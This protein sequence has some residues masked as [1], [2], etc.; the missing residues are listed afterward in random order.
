MSKTVLDQILDLEWEM[1]SQVKSR[2][3]VK[4]Q[5]SP[6]AFRSI[7]GSLFATW[8]LAM[9]TSYLGDLVA[10]R[11]LGRNLLT[12]KYA[13]MDG[14][15]EP[16]TI[17]PLIEVVVDLETE[18]QRD[19]NQRYPALYQLC[20]RHTDLPGNGSDFAIYLHCELETYG[21]DTLDLY[22]GNI[23]SAMADGRNL[24]TE[25]LRHLARAAGYSDL[26]QAEAVLA[27]KMGR[28]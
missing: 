25:A 4:C 13:R 21:V 20:C 24:A 18:W 16:L 28:R 9:L 22:Y 15:I 14:L 10:A 2:S 17:N 3:P 6:D 5:R 11:E 12:E 27:Q 7:R 23:K 8:T 19:L 26:D 1:F